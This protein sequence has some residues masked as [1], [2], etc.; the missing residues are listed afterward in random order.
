[1]SCT[2]RSSDSPCRARRCRRHGSRRCSTSSCAWSPPEATRW[3][4]G[5]FCARGSQPPETVMNAP[6]ERPENRVDPKLLEILVCPLTKGPRDFD[7]ARQGVVSRSAK[8]AYPIRDGIPIM[9]R[10]EA[11][12]ID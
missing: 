10:E 6:T 8:L 3:A 7:P 2:G 12:K 1:R 9:L 5:F 4:G 11:R